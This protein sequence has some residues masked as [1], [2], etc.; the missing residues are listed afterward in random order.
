MNLARRS[1]SDV[2]HPLDRLLALGRPVVMGI[3]NVTPDSFSDGGAFEQPEIA[4][5]HARRM[6]AEGA[7]ILDI[8]GESTR[9]YGSMQPVTLE[10]ELRRIAPILP[11]AVSLGPPVSIDTIKAKVAEWALDHGA[12][13]INDVWG[14]QRDTDMARIVAERDQRF[15]HGITRRSGSRR[16][17]AAPARSRRHRAHARCSRRS[18][19]RGGA[20]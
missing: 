5:A 6:A 15:G 9:P 2:P 7:D 19:P 18:R 12:A 8:G 20:R 10:E 4:I 3:L 14:L 13:I 1:A 11:A 16:P 17:R